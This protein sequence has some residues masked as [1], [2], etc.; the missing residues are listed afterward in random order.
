MIYDLHTHT[1]CSDGELSPHD[2]IDLAK[3]QGVDVLSITDHY[4]ITAYHQLTALPT[5][6]LTL[7][8]GI[9]F[10]TQWDNCNIHV[11]GLN[12][13]L[14]SE[15]IKT[16]I[17]ALEVLRVTRAKTIAEKLERLGAV[18]VY[19]GAKNIAK[20]SVIGRPH[21]ASFLVQSGFVKSEK[22]AFK[23]YLGK[24]KA[25]DVKKLWPSLQ[26]IVEW[27]RASG[28]LPVLAHPG[29]YKFTRAKLARLT[30]EFSKLGGRGI[31]VLSGAQLPNKTRDYVALAQEY[32][33][34]CSIGSDFHSPKH[35]WIQLGMHKTLPK[36]CRPIWDA[37]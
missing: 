20:G 15:A 24:G 1:N 13:A 26:T 10:S 16:G 23:Q 34:L 31:E 33:L 12:V 4:T 28:G 9:E 18:N 35:S 6:G 21:F 5:G 7:I 19:E 30:E 17:K 27:I 3:N 37:F 14:D 32:G 22:Q 11:V 29:H 36:E 2:L 8:P 25:G